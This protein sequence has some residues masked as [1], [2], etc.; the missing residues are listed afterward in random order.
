[1]HNILTELEKTL[2]NELCIIG[3]RVKINTP[4]NTVLHGEIGTVVAREASDEALVR[5]DTYK[6]K[7][8]AY[9]DTRLGSVTVDPEELDPI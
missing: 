2:N 8:D 6:P 3:L 4:Y 9:E 7:F 5:F 1:M